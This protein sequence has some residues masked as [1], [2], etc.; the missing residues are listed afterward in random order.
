MSEKSLQIGDF[1]E[2][3][4]YNRRTAR[5]LAFKYIFQW[6]VRGNEVLENMSDLEKMKFKPKDEAYIRNIVK[7]VIEN[8]ET[9]DKIIEEN[10]KGWK[11]GRISNVCLA[12]M[13]LALGEMLYDDEI[14]ESISIN[15][16]V[17]LMKT[18]DSPEAAAFVNGV[19]GGFQ[20]QKKTEADEK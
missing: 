13:R 2:I 4:S 19:L 1:G 7:V 5:D 16:A 3:L 8:C 6:N 18:Y 12:V 11:K 9:L 15:E 20:K 17:E 14:G 10:S